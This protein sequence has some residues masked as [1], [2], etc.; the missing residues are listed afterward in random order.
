MMS[1]FVVLAPGQFKTE[2][3]SSELIKLNQNCSRIVC[4]NYLCV[5]GSKCLK[6]LQFFLPRTLFRLTK[7]DFCVISFDSRSNTAV[8][9]LI[10]PLGVGSDHGFGHFLIIFWLLRIFYL[11]SFGLFHDLATYVDSCNYSAL[12]VPMRI[13]HFNDD[14]IIVIFTNLVGLYPIIIQLSGPSESSNTFFYICIELRHK[15]MRKIR[16]IWQNKDAYGLESM[17]RIIQGWS[18]Q[19]WWRRVMTRGLADKFQ[20]LVTN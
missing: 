15:V 17:T 6:F 16:V 11:F 10:G 12:S 9:I 19:C 7:G 20:M 8:K 18:H 5:F 2:P 13:T 1:L 3:K 14:V 4:W